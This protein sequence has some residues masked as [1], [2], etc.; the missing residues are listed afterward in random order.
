MEEWFNSIGEIIIE[1]IRDHWVDGLVALGT[2]FIGLYWGKKRAKKNWMKKEFFDRLNISLNRIENDRLIIRTILE[3]T[4]HEVF[5]NHYATEKVLAA[6]KLTEPGSPILP[7]AEDDRWYLLNSVLNEI[8]EKFSIFE[9]G[10][11]QQIAHSSDADLK[12][13][14]GVYLFCITSE[15]E[16]GVRTRKIRAMLIRKELLLTLPE[17]APSFERPQH[18]TRWQTLKTMQK[19]YQS[20]PSHFMEITIPYLK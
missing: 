2:L 12:K 18:A 5:L 14:A 7:L 15:A 1:A 9:I 17:S 4:V 6:A 3:K 16:G 20:D 10:R 19:T 8:A 11:D 13:S